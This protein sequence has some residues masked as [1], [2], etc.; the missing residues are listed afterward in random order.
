[1]TFRLLLLRLVAGIATT[2][3]LLGLLASRV[4]NGSDG[5]AQDSGQPRAEPCTAL[6]PCAVVPHCASRCSALGDDAVGPG[7]VGTSASWGTPG[8]PLYKQATASLQKPPPR[9]SP[10]S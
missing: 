3:L 4:A 1:M 7:P 6:A 9:L 8:E 2:A 10:L 5:M